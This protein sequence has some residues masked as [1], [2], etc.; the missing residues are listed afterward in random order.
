MAWIRLDCSAL[1]DELLIVTLEP[2]EFKAWVLFLLRVKAEGARGSVAM[3]SHVMLE[4]L[5]NVPTGTIESMMQKVDGRIYEVNGQW[6]VLN[7]RK[8]QEDWRDKSSSPGETGYRPDATTPHYTTVHYTTPQKDKKRARIQFPSLDE[9]KELFTSRN[10]HNASTEAEKFWNYYEANGWRVGKNPMK[11]WRAAAA[12]W[13]SRAKEYVRTQAK[14]AEVVKFRGPVTKV[15]ERCKLE[16]DPS[17]TGGLCPRCYPMPRDPG[18]SG[19]MSGLVESIAK[20][21]KA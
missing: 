3:T 17:K 7:W 14:V 11:D 19:D 15:C 5:W 4:R 1:S 9:A 13:N 16:F 12:G 18:V 20:G 6:H 8:Y 10:Y 21:M 2:A